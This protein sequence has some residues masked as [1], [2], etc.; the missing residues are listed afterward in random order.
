MAASG[1]LSMEVVGISAASTC[2][3]SLRLTV[4]RAAAVSLSFRRESISNH[5]QSLKCVVSTVS[6]RCPSSSAVERPHQTPSPRW[7]AIERALGFPSVSEPY[8]KEIFT[9]LSKCIPSGVNRNACAVLPSSNVL[10]IGWM[11]NEVG[12][13]TAPAG[14]SSRNTSPYH[15]APPSGPM[16]PE[17]TIPKGCP[18]NFITGSPN[19]GDGSP[20]GGVVPSFVQ[21]VPSNR[22]R[23]PANQCA[24]CLS[25]IIIHF[26]RKYR[27]KRV[28]V[29]ADFDKRS[30]AS[31]K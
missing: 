14:I 15:R 24:T 16:T 18:F 27:M 4:S 5:T 29:N 22:I 12:W 2:S 21:A 11:L 6:R 3:I 17:A 28:V 23:H 20:P 1:T 10:L 7:K 31:M 30:A 25:C 19:T 26:C 8:R 9:A 13:L